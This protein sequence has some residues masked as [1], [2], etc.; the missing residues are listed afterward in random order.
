M[1]KLN[2]R[3]YPASDHTLAS[4]KKWKQLTR[5]I[6]FAAALAMTDAAS[7]DQE[8]DI[9]AS[10]Q[11]AITFVQPF[12]FS[13]NIQLDGKNIP[14]NTDIHSIQYIET[15]NGVSGDMSRAIAIIQ[16]NPAKRDTV[17]QLIR[18]TITSE[19]FSGKILFVSSGDEEMMRQIFPNTQI[20]VSSEVN[21]S[22]MF[23]IAKN[24]SLAVRLMN[25]WE[26]LLLGW[27]LWVWIGL[28]MR[29]RQKQQTKPQEKE[30]EL[31]GMKSVT[32]HPSTEEASEITADTPVSTLKEESDI[33]TFPVN[34]DEAD[35][36]DTKEVTLE[37]ISSEASSTSD[38]MKNLKT[39][40]DET[41]T[42]EETQKE[43][44]ISTDDSSPD[45]SQSEKEPWLFKKAW[46]AVRGKIDRWQYSRETIKNV[47]G[48]ELLGDNIRIKKIEFFD[49]ENDRSS[50]TVTLSDTVDLF[51][52]NEQTKILSSP[53]Y[54]YS[55][56]MKA[57]DQEYLSDTA[58]GRPAKIAINSIVLNG[59]TL[60]FWLTLHND[61]I[62][63]QEFQD[64]GQSPIQGTTDKTSISW[65]TQESSDTINQNQQS[66][67]ILWRMWKSIKDW[68]TKRFSQKVWK[69]PSITK[70]WITD[71]QAIK[72]RRPDTIFEESLS[73][74]LLL[75]T[76][77]ANQQEIQEMHT[78]L[79]Q[80]RINQYPGK[81]KDYI[82]A[83]VNRAYKEVYGESENMEN[84]D[85]M[86]DEINSPSSEIK[87][88]LFDTDTL[89]DPSDLPDLITTQ[90]TE[91][92]IFECDLS[93]EDIIIAEWKEYLKGTNI[94][95]ESIQVKRNPSKDNYLCYEYTVHT[96]FAHEVSFKEWNSKQ[97]AT[98]L[99]IYRDPSKQNSETLI[100]YIY[101][102]QDQIWIKYNPIHNT[103][104]IEKKNASKNENTASTPSIQE[105]VV[106]EIQLPKSPAMGEETSMPAAIE[107]VETVIDNNAWEKETV[108]WI[109][110]QEWNPSD[111]STS[112]DNSWEEVWVSQE[113]LP[114]VT[115]DLPIE[116]VNGGELIPD[117]PTPVAAVETKP[118]ESPAIAEE[119]S[120]PASI[121]TQSKTPF[122]KILTPEEIQ[123]IEG[124]ELLEG[125]MEIKSI[126]I[127]Q[128][129]DHKHINE[130]FFGIKWL[131]NEVKEWVSKYGEYYKLFYLQSHQLNKDKLNIYIKYNHTNWDKIS[132]VRDQVLHSYTPEEIQAIEWIDIANKIP[133]MREFI[134]SLEK[135]QGG[136]GKYYIKG[137][138]RSSEKVFAFGYT[139]KT[140]I[141]EVEHEG[142]KYCLYYT[143][144]TDT[145]AIEEVL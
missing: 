44:L 117:V 13:E 141:K 120:T 115:R 16:E 100:A 77:N 62:S 54:E 142:K 130:I 67:S 61:Q 133:E 107:T 119:T 27:V 82:E 8:T 34:K 95:I 69:I 12:A 93:R 97:S 64:P 50:V 121:E 71:V 56:E 63:I 113:I 21:K 35:T 70:E 60:I 140:P 76:K 109:T 75:K 104:S 36:A 29:R 3:N 22:G 111:D 73:N 79:I 90:E 51:T 14:A 126:E 18:D 128:D 98:S 84:M 85:N 30:D 19:K 9:A 135:I 65:D 40:P 20:K 24:A 45:D 123:A 136:D 144:S 137:A 15:I 28:S 92:S 83:E 145:F 11:P 80:I 47:E 134:D 112:A 6:S 110:T 5:A 23:L 49:E 2:Q 48:K 88:E 66:L 46:S 108:E 39:E 10:T 53:H 101:L 143:P 52:S 106:Q 78:A 55:D 125:I 58:K 74:F 94:D 103:L 91:P 89:L 132:F 32:S 33:V 26:A 138:N 118:P 114:D 87:D 31:P 102:D 41:E 42:K 116:W 131:A 25:Q 1:S 37:A 86:N 72:L 127:V 139:R 129:P 7:A 99:R 4:P 17:I 124:I 59:K 68:Y 96:T 81:E 105:S 43:D 38:E 57:S 122:H